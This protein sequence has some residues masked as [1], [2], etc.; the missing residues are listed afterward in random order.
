MLVQGPGSL[1]VGRG[2]RHVVDDWDPHA[3]VG[4]QTEY[5]YGGTD[6]ED[7]DYPDCLR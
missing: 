2:D 5:N 1:V 4:L 6:E 3:G 7:R